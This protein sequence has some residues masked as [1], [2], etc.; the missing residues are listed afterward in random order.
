[1]ENNQTLKYIPS[2]AKIKVYWD[3]VPEDFTIEGKK[4]IK[5]VIQQMYGIPRQSI[6]VVE[7]PIKIDDSG[8][9]IEIT[10]AN[11]D[12]LIDTTHLEGLYKEWIK[13][14]EI[15]V[16]FDHLMKLDAKVNAA[17]NYVEE[18]DKRHRLW[19]LK[20]L[21]IDKFL[22]YGT[23]NVVFFDKLN[24]F[25]IVTSEPKN[26]G[27][28]SSFAVDSVMFLLFGQTTKTDKN[29]QIFNHFTNDNE[30]FVKGLVEIDNIEYI[31]KRTL[32][33]KM[34]RDGTWNVTGS[35]EYY[36]LRNDGTEVLL[37]GD[38]GSVTSKKIEETIGDIED[39]YI[40][41]LATGKN[42]DNLI[43]NT[44]TTTGKLLSKFIGV[45]FIEKK[46]EGVRKLYNNFTKTMLSNHYDL[47]QLENE[48][49]IHHET[50]ENYKIIVNSHVANLN[51]IKKKIETLHEDKDYY[52]GTKKPVSNS[53]STLNPSK[54]ENEILIKKTKQTSLNQ[55]LSKLDED[56][57]KLEVVK[58]DED[59]YDLA[60]KEEKA[61]LVEKLTN[62]KEV[63]TLE[64]KKI[65][66]KKSEIC[67]EC[68]RKLD[69]VDHTLHIN[70]LNDSI[71]ALNNK[72][73]TQNKKLEELAI[74]IKEHEEL[75]K[76]IDQQHSL[77]LK[78]SKVQLDLETLK[79][80]LTIMENDLKAYTDN[81]SA[82]EFNKNVDSEVINIKTKIQVEDVERE[83]LNNLINKGTNDIKQ[84]EKDIVAKDEL[85]KKINQ[86]I[87]AEK[88]YKVYIEMMGKNG[89]SRL[90]LRSVL[91]VIN[92][93]LHRL[94]DDVCDFTV[95]LNVNDK[96][97]IEKLIIVDGVSKPLKSTS[98]YERVL[99]ALALR[100]V[101]GRLSSLP[102]PNF[103]I[104]D[105]ILGPV[106]DV[107]L[108]SLKLLFDKIK[109]MYDIIF[110]ITHDEIAKSWS[111]NIINIVKE[112]NISR[113]LVK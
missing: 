57:K 11:I 8:K 70:K 37:T 22:S 81:L 51:K 92:L 16:N 45:E 43:D 23:N 26:R 9:K 94:L 10:G 34:K 24:G 33:R 74:E 104:F 58:F 86:E 105:E 40:T 97:D 112:N 65:N 12:S 82:I 62:E 91:P 31:I 87:K 78:R 49:K 29:E 53:I 3:S 35:V 85:V 32:N 20:W 1:M 30:L 89:I 61:L 19:K 107:N 2:N 88:I 46:E 36:E 27:G 95:E 25:N 93:E 42:L 47:N 66:L 108:D 67:S 7:R 71:L 6:I 84:H 63:K 111:D 18:Q 102:K 39:F 69:N 90:I 52:L 38:S 17:I 73:I 28:K 50:V 113:L 77:E 101:L 4:R 44:S 64:E 72:L 21:V 79:T 100:C 14:R 98:G 83:K 76:L 80:E 99:S 106:A 13:R 54:L 75:K 59:N 55:E 110:F 96:N 56:I 103:I 15:D 60:V 5:T 68:N 48:I 41:I 109:D